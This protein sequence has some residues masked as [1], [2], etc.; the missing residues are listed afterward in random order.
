VKI[1]SLNNNNNN[2]NKIVLVCRL[3]SRV[4][5]S[6]RLSLILI[7]TPSVQVSDFL[8]RLAGAAPTASSSAAQLSSSL[9]A[10]ALPSSLPR[11]A[12][13]AIPHPI[14]TTQSPP[15]PPAPHPLHVRTSRTL[16]GSLSLSHSTVPASRRPSLPPAVS[17]H[18]CLS[19]QVLL[20]PR[21][22]SLALLLVWLGLR[23]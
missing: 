1:P 21:S 14:A 16:S 2:N 10:R 5:C 9:V 15:F 11:P 22:L 13:L 19:S 18:R 12:R 4:H 20:L 6:S 8:R 3:R 7:F 17:T 23:G